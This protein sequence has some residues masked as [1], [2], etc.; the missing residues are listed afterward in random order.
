MIGGAI[1]KL[2]K[3]DEPAFALR[4]MAGKKK[5]NHPQSSWFRF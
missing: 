1:V 2:V 4:A 5:R 3:G